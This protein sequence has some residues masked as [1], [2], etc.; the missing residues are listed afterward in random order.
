MV[1]TNKKNQQLQNTASTR[2][3]L[4]NYRIRIFFLQKPDTWTDS[5]GKPLN[6]KCTHTT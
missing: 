5:F 1:S 6:W 4:L 2:T 3:L